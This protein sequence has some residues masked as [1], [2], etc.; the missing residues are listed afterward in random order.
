MEK[1]IL[2]VLNNLAQISNELLISI[3]SL[4]LDHKITHNQKHIKA[5]AGFKIVGILPNDQKLKA[6]AIINRLVFHYQLPA[7]D[8]Y[9]SLP[10]ISN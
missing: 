10:I 1:G 8:F 7:R 6:K 9:K 2:L 4:S 3:K 5:N